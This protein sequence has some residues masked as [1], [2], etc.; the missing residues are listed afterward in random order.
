MCGSPRGRK[1]SDTTEQL[2]SNKTAGRSPTYME[3]S[4][5][6]HPCSGRKSVQMCTEGVGG[7][8]PEELG[9]RTV[10]QGRLD[11]VTLSST[12]PGVL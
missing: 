4:Q 1:E 2:N 12:F 10:E 9:A 5:H 8:K 11:H 7:C 6:P 3:L